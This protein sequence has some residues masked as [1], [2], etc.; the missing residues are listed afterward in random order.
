MNNDLVLLEIQDRVGLLTLNHPEKRNAL[1]REMLLALKAKLESIQDND[2]V[3]VVILKANG[4]VFSS[5][6]DLRELV[7]KPYKDHADLFALCSEVMQLIQRM[8]QPVIAQVQG[9]ATAA[10]CQLVATCD[11]AVAS[12]NAQFATPGVK[13]G[14]FCTTPGVALARA[15]SQ[16]KAMEMLLTG[17]PISAAEAERAGLI[18][19]VVQQEHLGPET[20]TLARHIALA[21]AEI[22]AIGKAAFYEQINLSCSEAYEAAGK[23]MAENAIAED[24]QEGI[25]AFL[26]KRKPEWKSHKRAVGSPPGT[27]L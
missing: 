25:K 12:D 9:L 1:S 11:L 24:A 20:M 15:V 19:R 5:G 13:I 26:E 7:D 2:A 17:N 3:G 23:V 27:G 14:L 10:G 6:H 22:V 18:N 4:P 8:P 16:K 21:S